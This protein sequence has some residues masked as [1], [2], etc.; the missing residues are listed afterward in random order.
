[1]F[2]NKPDVYHATEKISLISSF[3]A[4]LF[5]GRVAPIDYADGSGMNLL[6]IHKNEWWDKA[7][8]VSFLGRL[9]SG[10]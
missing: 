5:L 2:Y 1:M 10:K 6:D 9:V 7:L 4:S 8:Y 3:A